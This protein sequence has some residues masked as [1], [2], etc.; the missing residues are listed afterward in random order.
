MFKSLILIPI[1]IYDINGTSHNAIKIIKALHNCHW[2]VSV[3]NYFAAKHLLVDYEINSD[4]IIS[5]NQQLNLVASSLPDDFD[6]RVKKINEL[7]QSLKVGYP[8]YFPF[9]YWKEELADGKPT[10]SKL[11]YISRF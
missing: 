11:W 2:Q 9:I 7:N 4:S 6:L 5:I 8:L 3:F 1:D 10:N